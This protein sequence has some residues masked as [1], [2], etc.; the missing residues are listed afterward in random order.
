VPDDDPWEALIGRR[1][2]DPVDDIDEAVYGP[3]K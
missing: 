3:A 2:D 1:D